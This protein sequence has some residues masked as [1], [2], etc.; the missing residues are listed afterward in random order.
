[1]TTP[2]LAREQASVRPGALEALRHRPVVLGFVGLVTLLVAVV[3]GIGL[4][5]V[6]IPPADTIGILAHQ[7]LGWPVSEAWPDSSQTIV[8]ELRLPRPWTLQL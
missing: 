4:G 3:A 8:M 5:T 2:D 6:T 1:M 7:L